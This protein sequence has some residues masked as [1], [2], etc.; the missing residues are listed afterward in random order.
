MQAI[1]KA[2]LRLLPCSD[3]SLTHDPGTISNELYQN[4]NIALLCEDIVNGMIAAN[5][6]RGSGSSD[7][8]RSNSSE[9]LSR[10]HQLSH[11]LHHHP[12]E[13]IVDI[14]KGDWDFKVQPG[15]SSCFHLSRVL[16]TYGRRPSK[17]SDEH[18]RKCTEIYRIGI[19][20]VETAR[21]GE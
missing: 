11:D 12:L 7:H 14:E 18:L 8:A 15:I 3:Q 19:H 16:L 10:N 1:L 2:C 17:G 4:T 6:F 20:N 21:C 9:L 13:V 5:E